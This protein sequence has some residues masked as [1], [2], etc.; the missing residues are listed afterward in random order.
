MVLDALGCALAATTLGD[1]CRESIAVMERLG[2]PPD[3]T[4]LG[5]GTKV[6]APNAAFVNGALVHALNY[7]PIG[8]EVGHLGVVCLVAPLAAAEMRSG[9]SGRAFIT[10]VAAACEV[11]ARVTAAVHRSGRRAEKY[12][13]GQLLSYFGA[14]VGAAHVLGLGGAVLRSALGL[15]LMQLA[16]SR[17]VVLAGDPPAKAIYG[18]FPNQAGLTA[19]L[20]A[21]EGLGADVD[22]LGAPA[23]LFAMIYGDAVDPAAVTE[24]LG[25]RFLLAD[26]QFKPWPTSNHVN[27]FIEA[28]AEI[29]RTGITV[30]DIAAVE[31]ALPSHVRPW[32]EPIE[33]RR[34]PENAAAAANAIPFC[35]AKALVHGDVGLGDVT[36]EGLRDAAARAV[37]ERTNYR[38]DDGVKG[39]LVS[40]TLRNGQ[41][42]EAQI[43]TPL[44]DPSRPMSDDRL[45]NKFRDCCTH[46]ATSLPPAAV[47]RLIGMIR[48]LETL[49][50]VGRLASLASG[51]V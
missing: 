15:A 51:G 32:V 33:T 42:R 4:I 7:D 24:G 26:V 46:A 19:A 18:A 43:D 27:P 14:T 30:S 48:D 9:I 34:R 47:E 17:Q 21:R 38:L 41:R 29:N 20:L 8:A 6:A 35:V 25:E 5:I 44:G 40:V 36:G 1:G 37:A 3:S 22:A 10:A 23:G 28:A 12:L 16:G 2:G 31:V 13:A 45:E 49:D 39:A 11:T 50:D